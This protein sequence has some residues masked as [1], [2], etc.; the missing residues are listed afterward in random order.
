MVQLA[1]CSGLADPLALTQAV[2]AY[3]GCHLIGMPECEASH[4]AVSLGRSG[5]HRSL[6]L[7]DHSTVTVIY[8]CMCCSAVGIV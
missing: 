1:L 6:V 3:Q 5:R 7:G 8:I 4:Y 2:S